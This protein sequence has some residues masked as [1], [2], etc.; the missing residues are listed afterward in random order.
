M[1]RTI[2]A[3]TDGLLKTIQTNAAN[4]AAQQREDQR[5]TEFWRE[6]QKTEEQAAGAMSRQLAEDRCYMEKMLEQWQAE[7]NLLTEQLSQ[8]SA[9]PA[10]G[11]AMPVD[12][13]IQ[14]I[15]KWQKKLR[16]HKRKC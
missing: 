14:E 2:K 10:G 3:N 1:Q 6:G 15:A 12:E 5:R 4:Y 16:T 7:R 8:A 13:H 9:Q 11:N